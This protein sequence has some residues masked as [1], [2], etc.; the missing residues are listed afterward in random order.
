MS[1]GKTITLA[2]GGTGFS[3]SLLVENVR[4]QSECE[5]NCYLG[6]TKIAGTLFHVE[7]V[8]VREDDDSMQV[9]FD[10]TTRLDDLD[11]VAQPD[12]PFDTIEVPGLEGEYVLYLYPFC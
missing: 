6:Q 11:A 4:A 1:E 5:P 12:G 7:L 2:T 10:D 3:G 8:R 9:P